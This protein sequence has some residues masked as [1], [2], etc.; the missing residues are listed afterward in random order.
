MM[1]RE[2]FRDMLLGTI[3]EKYH[4]EVYEWLDN[5]EE[6]FQQIANATDWPIREIRDFYRSIGSEIGLKQRDICID[7]LEQ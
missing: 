4:H 6:K 3:D 7:E 1:E 2:E 5:A